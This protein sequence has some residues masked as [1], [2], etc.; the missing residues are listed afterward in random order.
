MVVEQNRDGV[1][2]AVRLREVRRTVAVE[3]GADDRAGG[4][5]GTVVAPDE[6]D[7]LSGGACGEGEQ[8]E[9]GKARATAQGVNWMRTAPDVHDS[10]L[11]ST[12][13]SV[14]D[15]RG[16]VIVWLPGLQVKLC[17]GSAT[18]VELCAGE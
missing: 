13:E 2:A 5:D 9:G 7:R 14:S 10:A 1:P 15:R 3:V 4:G 18:T 6:R 12:L 8:K 16:E 17:C 11:R